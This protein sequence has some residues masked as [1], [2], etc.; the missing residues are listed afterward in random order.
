[1]I[2]NYSVKRI[3]SFILICTLVSCIF[4]PAVFAEEQTSEEQAVEEQA[5]EEQS[6]EEQAA[7]EQAAEEQTVEEQ[8]VEEQENERELPAFFQNDELNRLIDEN[9]EKVLENGYSELRIPLD[10][11]GIPMSVFSDNSLEVGRKLLEAGYSAY[12]IGGC[13]RD[14][15]MGTDSVD[16][17]ITTNASIEQQRELF[18]DA[19]VIHSSNGMD[20]GLVVFEDEGVD[21][22]TFQNIPAGYK[23]IPGVPEFDESQTTSDSPLADSFQRDLTLNA[24]YYDLSNGDLLDF[25]DGIYDIRE[26]ILD[27]MVD[28]DTELKVDPRVLLRSI[29]FR[30]RYGYNLSDRLDQAIREHGKEYAKEIRRY[31][32]FNNIRKMMGAGYSVRAFNGLNDYDLTG[33]MYPPLKTLLEDDEAVSKLENTLAIMDEELNSTGKDGSWALTLLA[34]LQPEIMRRSEESDPAAALQSVLDEQE[35]VFDLSRRRS[36]IEETYLLTNRLADPTSEFFS[37]SIRTSDVFD[38]ARILLCMR[39]II[40]ESYQKMAEFW[41][42]QEEE[43]VEQEAA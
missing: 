8:A 31:D 18:G 35:Q 25:H 6:V 10:V 32:A 43:E 16:I 21:L 23:G 24:I 34:L 2:K 19:L 1:M 5:A 20:F 7:E 17:D 4:S 36:E 12:V 29:R 37:E 40:D 30:A 28:A 39:A 15:I 9:H 3:F 26:G 27:T 22:A 11:H 42:D 33:T 38:D 14:F 41:S 13:T